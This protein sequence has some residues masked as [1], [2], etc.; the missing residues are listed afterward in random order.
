MWP[1]YS[2]SFIRRHCHIFNA[3]SETVAENPSFREAWKRALHCIIPADAFL[4][5]DWRS[6]KAIATRIV[7][8]RR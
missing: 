3:K 8:G 5:P 4:E 2:A 7:R 6:G 1:G